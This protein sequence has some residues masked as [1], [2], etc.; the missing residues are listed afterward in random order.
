MDIS[1]LNLIPLGGICLLAFYVACTLGAND[2]ANSMGTSVGSKAITLTQAIIIA[3]VL[4]FLGA[5][6][7]G[8]KVSETLATGVVKPEEFIRSPQLFQL[9]MIA[10]LIA[11]GLWL[12]IATRKG[13]PVAS[14]HGVVGAIS[15]FSAVA[16]GWGAVAWKT[17]GLISTAWL[18]TPIISA[19]IAASLYG[20]IK[21]WILD[22]PRPNQQ[23][24]EW[25]PWLSCC[26]ITVFG[27]LVLPQISEPLGDWIKGEFNLNFPTHDLTIAIAIIAIISLT[28][29][30][31]QP[32]FRSGDS[33]SSSV[34]KQLAH[35]QI[36]SA[37]F[38]AFAH[39]SNDVGN[40]IAPLAIIYY[41]RKTGSVPLGEFNIPLWI[42]VI[43][44][45]GIATGLAIWGKKVISTVGENIITLT[46]S[47]GFAAELATATTVLIA[48]NLGIPVSTSHALVGGVVGVGLVQ[49]LKSIK[50]D[51]VRLIVLAWLITVPAAAALAAGG[52]IILRYLF[53]SS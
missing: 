22:H 17:V 5:V 38:V 35:F 1:D 41:I 47:A 13:L 12:Q 42:L 31:W 39:G 29:F 37:C 4:E 46:P 18:I 8:A 23:I 11:T 40:T 15:G 33:S 2:V 36:F 45:A 7:F 43:G 28:W 20:L 21:H 6:L 34:E 44:G 30:S 9:G 27:T 19:I 48:S 10:V 14:S 24:I 16:A 53:L 25:T 3:G 32:A 52:F 51:T 26:L 49:G 50:F